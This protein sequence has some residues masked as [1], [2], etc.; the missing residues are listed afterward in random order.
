MDNED[1][2]N[3]NHHLHKDVF[4]YIDDLNEFKHPFLNALTYEVL[5]F[6]Y[7]SLSFRKKLIKTLSNETYVS[8]MTKGKE[9]AVSFSLP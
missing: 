8:S 4:L 6:S 5:S 9:V 1:N 2:Q 3:N 7:P